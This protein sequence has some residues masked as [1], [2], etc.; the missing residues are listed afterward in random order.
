MYTLIY[1]NCESALDAQF[2]HEDQGILGGSASQ[3]ENLYLQIQ[4]IDA[5]Y[6]HGSVTRTHYLVT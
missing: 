6:L 3:T 1:N 2:C 5:K 4:L